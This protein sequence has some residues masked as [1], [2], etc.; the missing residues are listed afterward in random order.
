MGRAQ[1]ITTGHRKI[2]QPDLER[3]QGN[4]VRAFPFLQSRSHKK[5][6]TIFAPFKS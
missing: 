6:S 4:Q 2:I 3:A 1:R 5:N